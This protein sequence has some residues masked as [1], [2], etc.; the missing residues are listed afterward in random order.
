MKYVGDSWAGKFPLKMRPDG[1]VLNNLFKI[2]LTAFET[3]VRIIKLNGNKGENTAK[4]LSYWMNQAMNNISSSQ[5]IFQLLMN[6]TNI[7]FKAT[8]TKLMK[9]DYI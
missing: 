7:D 6:E 1:G 4:F 8:I 9:V 5:Q 3:F 2:L